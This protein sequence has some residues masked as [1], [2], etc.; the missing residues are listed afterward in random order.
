MLPVEGGDTA[1]RAGSIRA[2]LQLKQRGWAIVDDVVP[3]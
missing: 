2:A 3:R 1:L